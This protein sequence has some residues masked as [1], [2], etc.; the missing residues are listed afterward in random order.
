IVPRADEHGAVRAERHAPDEG[1]R[2]ARAR[3]QSVAGGGVPQR[4][5][6]GVGGQALAIRA[7]DEA[8]DR[9]LLMC[10]EGEVSAAGGGVP[11]LHEAVLQAGGQALAVGAEDHARDPARPG[12]R[13]RSPTGWADLLLSADFP[14]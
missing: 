11:D 6:T 4:N 12:K 5:R 3:E 9:L 10:F 8:I 1:H 7:E 2:L 14:G 13:K